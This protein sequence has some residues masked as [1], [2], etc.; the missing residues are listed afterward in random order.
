MIAN[1]CEPTSSAPFSPAFA[2]LS[3]GELNHAFAKLMNVDARF[4]ASIDQ[5]VTKSRLIVTARLG[6]AA[7]RSQMAKHR[8]AR[9]WRGLAPGLSRWWSGVPDVRQ[10]G[11][12]PIQNVRF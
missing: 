2:P 1:R 3:L 8:R 7:A 12:K 10:W 11:I 5:L 9:P 4:L 6:R